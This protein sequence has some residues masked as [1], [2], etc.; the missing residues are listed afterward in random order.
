MRQAECQTCTLSDFPSDRYYKLIKHPMN[1]KEI[2][3]KLHDGFYRSKEEIKRDLY[4]IAA[5]AKLYN[6]VGEAIWRMA[7]LYE[8]NVMKSGFRPHGFLRCLLTDPLPTQCG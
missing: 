1:L 6:P 8:E 5:N 2:Q 4:L 3:A 7:D